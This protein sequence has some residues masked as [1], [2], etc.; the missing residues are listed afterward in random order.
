MFLAVTRLTFTE[1]EGTSQDRKAM[2]ALIDRIRARHK[3]AVMPSKSIEEHGV[4]QITFVLLG[5]NENKLSQ[6]IDAIGELCEESGFGR[7]E[8]EDT[9]IDDIDVIMDIEE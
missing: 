8:D 2:H 7:I 6:E 5:H 3:V 1:D 9:M 4:A